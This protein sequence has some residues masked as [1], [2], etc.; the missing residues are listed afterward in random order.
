MTDR[1]SPEG[2]FWTKVN[3]LDFFSSSFQCHFTVISS[4]HTHYHQ[5]FIAILI[6]ISFKNNLPYREAGVSSLRLFLY[7]LNEERMRN[8]FERLWFFHSH[9]GLIPSF[10]MR[11][12]EKKRILPTRDQE[13][14][15]LD[16]MNPIL[17]DGLTEPR[18]KFL[19]KGQPLRFFFFLIPISFHCYLIIPYS[20]SSVVYCNSHSHIIQE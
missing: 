9:S 18:G 11:I 8:I 16:W 3:P 20:L 2:E 15:T 4:F 12:N 5:S 14:V 7:S 13:I 1:R 17:N 6:H 10:L 19:N